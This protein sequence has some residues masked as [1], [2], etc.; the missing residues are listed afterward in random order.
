MAGLFMG[1]PFRLWAIGAH[2][3]R[4]QMRSNQSPKVT[5]VTSAAAF[6][7]MLFSSFAVDLGWPWR[8]VFGAIALLLFVKIIVALRSTRPNV[9]GLEQK[10]RRLAFV[11]G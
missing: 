1:V 3:G 6:A 2:E 4:G 10:L 5:A 11:D 7:V 8:M 9:G